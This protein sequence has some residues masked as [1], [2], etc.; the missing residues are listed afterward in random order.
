MFFIIYLPKLKLPFLEDWVSKIFMRMIFYWDYSIQVKICSFLWSLKLDEFYLINVGVQQCLHLRRK[1]KNLIN[2]ICIFYLLKTSPSSSEDQI[3]LYQ[4][5]H[6]FFNSLERKT[7][8][9]WLV[10]L[11]PFISSL[12]PPTLPAQCIFSLWSIA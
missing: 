7:S 8:V 1:F 10:S 2:L 12:S 9:T 4:T 6:T 3:L 5:Y 11:L